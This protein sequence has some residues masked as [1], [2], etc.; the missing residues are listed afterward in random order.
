MPAEAAPVAD[1]QGAM[2]AAHLA[3]E[4]DYR[5]RY[6]PE[7]LDAV[8]AEMRA[9][10]LRLAAPSEPPPEPDQQYL[11]YPLD[12]TSIVLV[13]TRP[14]Y[15]AALRILEDT[16]LTGIDAEYMPVSV[17]S[18]ETLALV[19][20]ATKDKVYLFDIQELSNSDDM[21]KEDWRAWIEVQQR[22]S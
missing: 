14:K 20:I 4:L 5:A 1:T 15:L 17:R 11:A 16:D 2:I 8:D 12:R 10:V 9:L 22:I 18:E 13:N 19:Q 21:Q 3:A 6:N 7:A